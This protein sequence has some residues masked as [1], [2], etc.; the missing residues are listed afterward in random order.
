MK[1]KALQT[2]NVATV[3]VA[4]QILKD[5]EMTI[6]TAALKVRAPNQVSAAA[7]VLK[8][9]EMSLKVEASVEKKVLKNTRVY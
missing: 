2:L 4:V 8:V 7:K 6:E 9:L 1:L 3:G 5:T